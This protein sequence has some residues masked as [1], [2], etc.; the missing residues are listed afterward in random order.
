MENRRPIYYEGNT[1]RKQEKYILKSVFEEK[2]FMTLV[3]EFCGNKMPEYR[4]ICFFCGTCQFCGLR[5]VSRNICN[6][7]GNYDTTIKGKLKK[8]LK[9]SEYEICDIKNNPKDKESS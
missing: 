4:A 8:V 9:R 3:C 5:A 6:F 2:V 1:V 7:C